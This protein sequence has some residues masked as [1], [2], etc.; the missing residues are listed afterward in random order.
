MSKNVNFAVERQ[1]KILELIQ[2]KGS[3]KVEEIVEEYEISKMTA[4]RD[5]KELEDRGLITKVYGGAVRNDTNNGEIHIDERAQKNRKIKQKLASFVVENYIKDDQVLFLD[6]GSTVSEIVQL[7]TQT[8]ITII[9]NGLRTLNLAAKIDRRIRIIGTGGEVRVKSLTMVGDYSKPVIEIYTANIFLTSGTGLSLENGITDPDYLEANIK[10]D[11][12]KRTKLVICL[13]DSSKLGKN[14][15]AKSLSV[16][17]IDVLVTDS[18]APKDLIKKIE[19]K[20]VKV[21]IVDLN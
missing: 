5:L 15:G 8:G 14:A 11:M 2:Q 1:Q 4:W 16:G 7:I 21:E 10:K 9:T 20:G 3:I 17:E 13:I 19:K 18:N 6:G 12:K